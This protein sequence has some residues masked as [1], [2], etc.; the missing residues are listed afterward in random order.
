MSGQ[1]RASQSYLSKL[2][3]WSRSP[4]V[5]ASKGEHGEPEP[6]LQQQKG[7][8][9]V[10]N[11]RH[12]MSLRRYPRDCP[13]VRPCW[14]HAADV[15]KRRP[16]PA[17]GETK[18]EKPAA[19]PKKY[20]A[21]SVRDSKAIEAAFQKLVENEDGG[22]RS[23]LEQSQGDIS[24]QGAGS[25]QRSDGKPNI[26]LNDDVKTVKVPVNEDYLFDVDVKHRE[27]APA[28]WLGPVYDVRRGTWFYQDGST[29]RPCDENL[30]AQLEE[31]YLK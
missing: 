14:F 16:N 10:V 15:P 30:A 17:A 4:V 5:P 23:S 20:S 28:Y 26:S 25:A 21:F 7:Q 22:E 27:L 11:H 9:H 1:D 8:D 24:L 29:Q 6:M 18:E 31:G 13:E 3:P 19:Q 2:S 12:R